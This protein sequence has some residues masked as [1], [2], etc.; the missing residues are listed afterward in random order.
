MSTYKQTAAAV[1]T[2]IMNEHNR[3]TKAIEIAS[4]LRQQGLQTAY[5]KRWNAARV[6][7]TI[8]NCKTRMKL[9]GKLSSTS[10]TEAI[11]STPEQQPW[12]T[13]MNLVL[14]MPI[15]DAT[16]RQVLKELL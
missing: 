12:R 7:A 6:N 11:N 16:K 10:V 2:F 3:G 15:S 4:K 1:R 5:G 13:Q 14:A 8:H 9:T